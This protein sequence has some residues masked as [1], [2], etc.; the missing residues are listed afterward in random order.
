MTDLM[1]D[2]HY[3]MSCMIGTKEFLMKTTVQK[4][5]HEWRVRVLIGISLIC[6]STLAACSPSFISEPPTPAAPTATY[7]PA[8]LF[9]DTPAESVTPEPTDA[10]APT[11]TPTAALVSIASIAEDIAADVGKVMAVTEGNPDQN[12][13]V[14]EET[15]ISP[16]GQIEIAIML[17]RLYEN[18]DMR[19][20]GLEGAFAEDGSLEPYRLL[21]SPPFRAR[22][23][24]RPREDVIV[25][26]LEDGET[27][28]MEMMAVVYDDV[29]VV[30]VENRDEYEFEIPEAAASATIVY[31]Y[32]IAALGLTPGEIEEANALIEEEKISEAID[33][34]I[35]TD[36]FTKE[37]Y[38]RL[39]DAT[40]VLPCEALVEL[41]DQI[42]AKAREVGADVTSEDRANLEAVREFYQRCSD[43][44][45]TMVQNILAL[46][47]QVPGQPVALSTGAAHTEKVIELLTDAGVSFAVLQPISLA[48]GRTA[49][50]LSLDAYDR[51]L[52]G[53][54]VDPPGTL[55][56]LLDG[57]KKPQP[58]TNSTWAQTKAEMSWL[59][60]MIARAAAEGQEPP[61]EEAL[62]EVLPALHNVTLVPD[63][64]QIVDG[65][66]V[67][68]ATLLNN[69][70]QPV[71]IWGRAVKAVAI[72]E[73]LLEERLF[74]SLANV[75]DKEPPSDEPEPST[76]SQPVLRRVSSDTIAIYSTDRAVVLA[77]KLLP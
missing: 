75:Q 4:P 10:P 69:D 57:R 53:L 44:S 27:S 16:A 6:L 39:N 59:T 70:S 74:E 9:T 28:G 50:D 71:T 68:S 35:N 52:L 47:E 22:D 77:T 43:R 55:G 21:N 14:F 38:A 7:A 56:P 34:I 62:K 12:I 42:D 30:G 25:Q 66:V 54:S 46:A 72:G 23:R 5:V 60:T 51:K 76:P 45:H 33:F 29:E 31:L 24:V 37:M 49:G 11:N 41:V 32:Q 63:S 40:I 19:R 15:H 36:E 65:D 48:E 26:M 18:Y 2:T 17:N 3:R 61:F 58:V 13:F 73:K 8:P 67:F 64:I 20:M 1:S